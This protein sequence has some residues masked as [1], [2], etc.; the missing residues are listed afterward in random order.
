[1]AAALAAMAWR[2]PRRVVVAA[3][4]AVSEARWDRF[5]A[6]VVLAW[7]RPRRAAQEDSSDG[8]RPAVGRRAARHGR[9]QGRAAAEYRR[10]SRRGLLEGLR[11]ESHIDRR[12]A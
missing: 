3:C 7:H 1:M 2:R 6:L 5:A 4:M 9:Y 8:K 11:I 10:R 12:R